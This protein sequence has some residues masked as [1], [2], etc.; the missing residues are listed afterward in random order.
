MAAQH[1]EEAKSQQLWN[2]GETEGK[3][4]LL[5]AHASLIKMSMVLSKM[6][7]LKNL[8]LELSKVQVIGEDFRLWE[9]FEFTR[10]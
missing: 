9:S 5:T 6:E 7:Y 10:A 8:I 4:P 3:V 1:K 2:F